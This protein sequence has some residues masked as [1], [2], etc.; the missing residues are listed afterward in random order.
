MVKNNECK[1]EITTRNKKY[2]NDKNY[3]CEVGDIISIDISTMAKK[4]HNIVTVICEICENESELSFVKYNI[5]F[6]RAGFYS[7]KK[8]SGVKRK[9][10]TLE[11]YGVE[12]A[13]Q[14]LDQKEKQSEWMSS[15]EFRDKS[16]KTQIDKYGSLFVQTDNFKK[17]NSIKIKE[18]I[19]KK[20]ENGEYFTFLSS[21]DNNELK[22]KGM[23]N[24]YGASYSFHIPEIK[25][26]IQESNLE[27]YGHISPFG[28]KEI[29]ISIKNNIVYKSLER[30]W[31]FNGDKYKL[32][33]FR[34]YRR[35]VR[36]E[37]DLLRQKLFEDWDGYDYYDNEYI[38][39]NFTLNKNDN[40][41]PSI[42]HKMSCFYGFINNLDT[43]II[44]DIS[45]LCITKRIINSKKS[46][47]N[48]DEFINK[49]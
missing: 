11:K 49:N 41:Y 39:E 8:C 5:N 10:T 25:K 20:K 37:T 6:D 18:N 38:K 48:E 33:L 2:Y 7:C 32:D 24:K 21:S 26:K 22:K 45:N 34:I 16:N 40:N 19:K 28:N 43:S 1:V 31:T 13:T 42:D 3:N 36:Y 15:K 35:K 23:F 17:D 27:K 44:S 46:Q 29:Q 47:L 30:E 9:K 14:R 4:S 12:Y